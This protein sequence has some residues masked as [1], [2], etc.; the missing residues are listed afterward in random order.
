MLS[1]NF[2]PNSKTTSE[3]RFFFNNNNDDFFSCNVTVVR[4]PPRHI[5]GAQNTQIDAPTKALKT[6]FWL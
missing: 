3:R 6:E 1:E 4:P 2:K 5:D